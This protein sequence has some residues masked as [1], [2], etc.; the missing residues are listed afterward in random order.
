M[1][2]N[3]RRYWF[4]GFSILSVG[5]ACMKFAWPG[6]YDSLIEPCL[7]ALVGIVFTGLGIYI[8]QSHW[9]FRTRAVRAVGKVV[10]LQTDADGNAYPRVVFKTAHGKEVVFKSQFGANVGMPKPGSP[11]GVYYDPDHP[12]DAKVASFFFIWIFPILFFLIGVF[13]AVWFLRK[14]FVGG[15]K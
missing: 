11:I 4:V 6:A 3:K 12:K 14:F 15:W 2:K 10:S 7:G 5:V 9:R 1:V 13:S 8:L